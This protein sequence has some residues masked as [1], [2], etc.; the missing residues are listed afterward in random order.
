MAVP[1]TTHVNV[2]VSL[3]GTG[4]QPAGFGN[5]LAIAQT[6][7]G[8]TSDR[9]A[10]PFASMGDV[11]DYGFTSTD[12]FY[13]I[14]SAVFAQSPRIK[15]LYLGRRLAGD[16]NVTATLN[17]CAAEDSAS[18]YGVINEDR[19]D[20]E[21]MEVAAWCESRF[22]M[23]VLQTDSTA[24]LNGT[25]Q[26]YTVTFGG[27]AT[28]GAYSI[29][30]TG[31]GLVGTKTVTITRAGGTPATNVLL[32]TAFAAE[33]TTQN[34][35]SGDIEGVLTDITD[36]LDGSVTITFDRTLAQCVVDNATATGPATLTITTDDDDV[37]RQMF[38]AQYTRA[39][40]WY[41][42]DDTEFLDGSVISR[43]FAFDLDQKKGIWGFKQLNGI[44][45]I[46]LTS[47][48]AAAIRSKNG[49]YYAPI[50]PTSGVVTAAYTSQGWLPYGTAGAGRRIDLQT[51]LDWTQARLEE[52]IL[53]VLLRETH[54]VPYNDAGITRFVAAVNAVFSKGVAAGHYESTVAAENT[55][56]AGLLTPLVVAPKYS[57]TTTTERATRTVTLSA[58]AYVR[59]AIEAVTFNVEV[60]Q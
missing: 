36:N 15:K 34:D 38:D 16:A 55:D 59:A 14:A 50:A 24:M 56:Y 60:R 41:H 7:V 58:M 44:P 22:K 29:D 20:A 11:T 19:T 12:A 42:D 39:S 27:T 32:A 31:A 28:D 43:C 52:A 6:T 46:N 53:D 26:V 18:W 49:N 54:S 25:G 3:E 13:D 9:V 40:L 37:A 30:F 2:S 10:G 5:V 23:A 8:G 1:I 51:T 57:E 33:L 45:S 17:A 4:T 21:I 47:A 35:V 48:Q